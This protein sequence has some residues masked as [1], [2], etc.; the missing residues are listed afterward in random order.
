MCTLAE[1]EA[2]VDEL[3]VDER[4]KSLQHLAQRLHAES[5]ATDAAFRE[6]WMARLDALRASIG[7]GGSAISGEQALTDAREE[8]T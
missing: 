7:T 4:Q 3:P 2:A 8:R 5:P 6:R 1:I